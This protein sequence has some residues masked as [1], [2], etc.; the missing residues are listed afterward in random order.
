MKT[1]HVIAIGILVPL[2]IGLVV[3]LTFNGK[4]NNPDIAV[5]KKLPETQENSEQQTT[6]PSP[7]TVLSPTSNPTQKPTAQAPTATPKPPTAT[8]ILQD[9][10]VHS[11]THSISRRYDDGSGKGV[12][13][14]NVVEGGQSAT[15]N[16]LNKYWDM[17]VRTCF[18]FG[19]K[20]EIQG[21]KITYSWNVDGT[22]TIPEGHFSWNSPLAISD[23]FQLCNDTPIN[24]GKHTIIVQFNPNK[25][26]PESNYTNNSA[27]LSYE[28]P[29]DKTAPTF[30]FYGPFKES[31]TVGTCLW[32]TNIHDELSN[33]SDLKIEVK[34]DSEQFHALD[35][36]SCMTGNAGDP[37]V[38]TAK[39]TDEAGNTT[40]K[41][42]DFTI[43]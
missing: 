18:G 5:D 30:D 39:V 43:Q 2:S 20:Q 10:Y 4:R 40:E 8:P 35:Q 38:Y 14:D 26:V 42:K 19:V 23:G 24:P 12:V 37:H 31:D 27:T 22:T 17:W 6:T 11:Q 15:F 13:T 41:T 21:E 9:I 25:K 33:Y 28:I 36:R 29:Q 7:E 3:G 16:Q 34:I 32:P 1:A